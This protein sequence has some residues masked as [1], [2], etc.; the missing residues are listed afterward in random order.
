MAMARFSF[1]GSSKVAVVSFNDLNK[2]EVVVVVSTMDGLSL[3]DMLARCLMYI[4]CP[5]RPITYVIRP[6]ARSLL[7]DWQH[8]CFR[9]LQFATVIADPHRRHAGEDNPACR[10]VVGGPPLQA[11][12]G[13]LLCVPKSAPLPSIQHLLP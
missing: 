7:T 4:P 13:L 3:S 2:P 12:G 10:L 5:D 1:Y 9:V 8:F 11:K 6:S